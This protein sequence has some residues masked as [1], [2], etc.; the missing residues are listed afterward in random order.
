MRRLTIQLATVL[1][2]TSAQGTTTEEGWYGPLPTLWEELESADAVVVGTLVEVKGRDAVLRVE[3]RLKGE[4]P[5]R[6]S[7]STGSS[8]DVSGAG[9][10]VFA[11]LFNAERMYRE[12]ERRNPEAKATLE[13]WRKEKPAFNVQRQVVFATG[14]RSRVTGLLKDALSQQRK[15]TARGEAFGLGLLRL[16]TT[17][18]EGLRFFEATGLTPAA[19]EELKRR[20]LSRSAGLLAA[21][22]LM[23][24]LEADPDPALTDAYLDVAKRW[25]TNAAAGAG[26]V[27]KEPLELLARRIDA[28]L[29]CPLPP[30]GGF[31][32]RNRDAAV[33]EWLRLLDERWKATRPR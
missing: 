18:R 32:V 21:A 10:Q 14:E 29:T 5:E 27:A 22:T 20:V 1:L 31:D 17:Q 8:G 11:L 13:Q 9:A 33:R 7:T 30:D 15:K 23:K 12:I 3:E 6:V 19:R 24:Q 28:S 2:A 25:L 4:A 26:A 16:E